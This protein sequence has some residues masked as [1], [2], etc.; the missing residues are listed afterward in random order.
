MLPRLEDVVKCMHDLLERDGLALKSFNKMDVW[1]VTT[2]Y[3]NILAKATNIE[4]V[5]KKYR[6]HE[7]LLMDVPN[8]GKRLI[9]KE[10]EKEQ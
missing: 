1:G 5:V 2:N 3:R 10:K 9:K 4:G 7:E 6:H 8:L